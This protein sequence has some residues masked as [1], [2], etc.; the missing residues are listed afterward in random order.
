MPSTKHRIRALNDDLRQ[1]HRGGLI[2]LTSGIQALGSD[3][4]Q[5]IDKAI[6]EFDGFG[7]AN[8]PYHEHDFGSVE[9]AGH[10]VFF[11]IDTYDLDLLNFSPDRSDP[12]VTRRVMTVMLAEEY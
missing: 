9:I 5:R 2:L 10:L 12:D 3:L 4:V 8:D 1:H 7:P 11:K 6:A